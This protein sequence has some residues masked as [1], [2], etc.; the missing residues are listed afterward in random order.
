MRPAL[1]VPRPLRTSFNHL[2]RADRVIIARL[3]DRL[4]LAMIARILGKHRTTI[5]RE[6]KRNTTKNA[7]YFEVHADARARK[8]RALS[9]QKAELDFRASGK[10]RRY[11]WDYDAQME[12]F[13][14]R[15]DGV[16]SG[17]RFVVDHR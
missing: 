6:V 4:N 8:R 7:A 14:V 3:Q 1:L 15:R 16:N 5:A 9:K 10:T 11:S 17:E 2:T 13:V 12:L